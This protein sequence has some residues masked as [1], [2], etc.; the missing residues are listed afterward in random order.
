[1]TELKKQIIDLTI[2]NKTAG[3]FRDKEFQWHLIPEFAVITGING[4]G[5]TKLLDHINEL[6]DAEKLPQTNTIITYKANTKI[7]KHEKYYHNVYKRPSIASASIGYSEIEKGK[8]ELKNHITEFL[9]KLSNISLNHQVNL[10][11]PERIL[12][13][14]EKNNGLE[15]LNLTFAQWQE[16]QDYLKF[17]AQ[18]ESI[19]YI[20]EYNVNQISQIIQ[21]STTEGIDKYLSKWMPNRNNIAEIEI[22]TLFLNYMRKKQTFES[23]AC[24]KDIALV[25]QRKEIV[26]KELEGIFGTSLAPWTV[27]NDTLKQYGFKHQIVEPKDSDIYTLSF[28]NGI[29]YA[30]L[31]TGEE[32]IFY[33]ICSGYNGLGSI[34]NKTSLLLLDELDAYL[35]PVMSKMF[36]EIVNDILVKKF[37]I[38]V[39]MTTHSPS[40]VAYTPEE[41]LFWMENGKIS[42]KDKMEIV[43]Q[44]ASGF[45]LEESSCPFMSYLTD[46]TK[47]YY[48]LVEGYTDRLHLQEACKKLGG[49]YQKLILGKCNFIQLGGTKGINVKTFIDN[50]TNGKKTIT[51]F[52]NDKS[53]NDI[54][55]DVFP[56]KYKNGPLKSKDKDT[57]CILLKSENV[58]DYKTQIDYG[59]IPI[60]FLYPKEIVQNF[61][62]NSGNKFLGIANCTQDIKN[63]YI[64][65]D[66]I[67]FNPPSLELL[68]IK[69]GNKIKIE[70]AE[71]VKTLTDEYFIGFKTTLDSV[72]QV[73]KDFDKKT[74]R[75]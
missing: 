33:L 60:E 64:Y 61:D 17:V 62:S 52:D 57:I 36:I 4:S 70:F 46:P 5:K 16:I 38:Q 71:Y 29:A 32:V 9:K 27:I 13:I 28:N 59:Y 14:I 40:T 45:T 50:F 68:Y 37:K 35:N 3:F 65:A 20:D 11:N 56:N 44:L 21:C 1:M 66:R 67:Q 69:S 23:I 51:L 18:E 48:I 25:E 2:S 49:D 10:E 8:I 34:Q 15:S 24:N 72:L 55:D 19:D 75:M 43:H 53:G 54:C 47:P 12:F 58:E 7:L 63:H 31:S 26:N 30:D 42:K 41:N 22:R 6:I 73:I 74:S 39:I